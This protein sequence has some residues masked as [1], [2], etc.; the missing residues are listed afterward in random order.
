[1]IKESFCEILN[2]LANKYFSNQVIYMIFK[3]AKDMQLKITIS[4]RYV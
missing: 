3:N 4:K 2:A 1:M